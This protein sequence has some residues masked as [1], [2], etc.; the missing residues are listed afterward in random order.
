MTARRNIPK[1]SDPPLPTQLQTWVD[2]WAERRKSWL[3]KQFPTDLPNFSRK[4]N[5]GRH[6]HYR[7]VTIDGYA[8]TGDYTFLFYF[9]WLPSEP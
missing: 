4:G 7:L 2:G 3:E 9:P 5:C 8:F 6:D 1:G